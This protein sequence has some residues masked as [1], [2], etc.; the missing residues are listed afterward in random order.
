MPG[1]LRYPH[2]YANSLSAAFWLAAWRGVM[3]PIPGH[4]LAISVIIGDRGACWFI[5]LPVTYVLIFP[6][7][8]RLPL[9]KCIKMFL[10]EYA[11]SILMHM[12]MICQ[13]LSAPENLWFQTSFCLVCADISVCM[14]QCARTDWKLSNA[15]SSGNGVSAWWA[16]SQ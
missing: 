14:P 12:E 4:Y 8:G 15:A 10:R 3:W 16:Y 11:N 2:E 6:D 5:C 9:V 13:M 1:S 7:V